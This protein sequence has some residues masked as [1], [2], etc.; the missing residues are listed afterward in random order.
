MNKNKEQEQPEKS[1]Q[2]KGSAV[3]RLVM[4]FG[5]SWQEKKA[6]RYENKIRHHRKKINEAAPHALFYREWA[7]ELRSKLNT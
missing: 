4:W 7:D 5:W 1:V 3:K 6:I 2:G